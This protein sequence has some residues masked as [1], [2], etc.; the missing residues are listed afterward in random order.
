MT[1]GRGANK[2]EKFFSVKHYLWTPRPN[3]HETFFSVKHYLQ[4]PKTN[5]Q[6]FTA[7]PDWGVFFIR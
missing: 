1:P 7:I 4:T 5:K 6:L 2:H 3:K